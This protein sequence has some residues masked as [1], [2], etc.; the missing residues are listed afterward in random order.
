MVARRGH[1]SALSEAARAPEWARN[2]RGAW[3][4]QSEG[5]LRFA[6]YWL[7]WVIETLEGE[8]ERRREVAND[9]ANNRKDNDDND[10]KDWRPAS[11]RQEQSSRADKRRKNGRSSRSSR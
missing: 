3:R 7:R 4:N 1:R 10:Q 5:A 8:L 2:L 9:Q 6:I 11:D